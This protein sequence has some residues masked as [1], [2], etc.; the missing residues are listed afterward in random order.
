MKTYKLIV[1]TLTWFIVSFGMI[2]IISESNKMHEKRP[3]ISFEIDIQQPSNQKFIIKSD[4]NEI[5]NSFN[6]HRDT[7]PQQ[8][9]NI[10]LLEETLRQHQLLRDAE[11]F[12]TWEGILQINL[13]QKSAKARMINKK[14]MSYIDK[15]GQKFPLSNHASDQLP[16]LTGFH[17]SISRIK[18]LSF[19]EKASKHSAF[20]NGISS[21]NKESNGS[22]TVYP[23][24]HDHFIKWGDP[25]LFNLKAH[26]AQSLYAHL[27]QKDKLEKLSE[28]YLRYKSQVVYKLNN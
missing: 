1:T 19:I 9:I 15:N 8:E 22:Y 18:A 4:F 25:N 28:L 27:L 12:S 6:I 2:W 7:I 5:L 21:I 24:W 11:V 14:I 23:K 17:D 26:K 16:L 10:A 3:I 20:P 13:F